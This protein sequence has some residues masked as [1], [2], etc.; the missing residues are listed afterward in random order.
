MRKEDQFV[1]KH[2]APEDILEF[3][4]PQLFGHPKGLMTLFFTEM[5]ERFS[6]YG[7]RALLILF[8]TAPIASGGLGFNDQTSGAIYGLYSMAV[9]LLALP[10]GW[11]ADRLIGLKKSVWYGGIIITIGHFTMA[12]PGVF[13]LLAENP[14]APGQLAAWDLPSFFLGL[15][16]I[17][18]GTGLLKPNISSIVGQLY[19]ENSPKRDAGFSIFYM[20]I[21]LG[22]FLAPIACSTLAVYDWHLGFGLA[23]FGMLMGLVQYKWTGKYLNGVGEAV[24]AESPAQRDALGRLQKRVWLVLGLVVVLVL[25]FFLQVIPVDPV[26]IAGVS[27]TMIAIVALLFFGY[28]L[29]FGGLDT[30]QKK[31]VLVIMILFVFSA[32]FWSGFEQAGSSLNL[33]AERFTDR[34]AMGWEIPAGYFQSVN[35]I[36]IILFAPF[37]GAMWVALA[38]KNLE[39]SSPLKFAIGLLFLGIGFL[40]MY[41]AAKIAASGNLAAPSWLVITYLFHT[42][43]ELSLS[44]V[45]LSLTTKLAPKRFAGQM[46]GMWFLSIAMGNLVAGRIAGSTSGGTEEALANMPQQYL[47]IV[48]TVAGAG[49]VLML[50]S[51][52]IR[53]L[54]G[55]IH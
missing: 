22:A 28:V 19:P 4:G 25:L 20:G 42:F 31:K 13:S 5:W 26:A 6:Y 39:P 34:M 38:R 27:N 47:L 49:I 36:F 8:M 37:F 9:Y 46:M 14:A 40:V 24:V 12:L 44:P 10:G 52:P 45:G 53:S 29:L 33:F 35:S 7:M 17:V 55:K 11:V 15:V 43:G 50:V 2:N 30:A 23:G 41:F 3:E 18:F 48:Y 51:K 16:L 32:V 21:N 1:G 54:M